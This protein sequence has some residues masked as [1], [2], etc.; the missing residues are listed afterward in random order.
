MSVDPDITIRDGSAMFVRRGGSWSIRSVQGS[1]VSV[2]PVRFKGQAKRLVA[3]LTR[4]NLD[5][6]RVVKAAHQLA[7]A[8]RDLAETGVP[9]RLPTGIE[10][11]DLTAA[12]A[13]YDRAIQDLKARGA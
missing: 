9:G 8:A 13:E 10:L 5:L 11:D 3:S 2:M 12:L 6:Q 1:T 4:A 7:A